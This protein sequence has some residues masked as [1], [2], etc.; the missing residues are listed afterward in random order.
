MLLMLPW[1]SFFSKALS[2]NFILFIFLCEDYFIALHGAVIKKSSSL[3]EKWDTCIG[4]KTQ[5]YQLWL[6]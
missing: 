4:D 3:V 2:L 6:L 1:L 5:L